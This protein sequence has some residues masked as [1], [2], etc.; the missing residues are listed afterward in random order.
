MAVPLSLNP[1][2]SVAQSLYSA[3]KPSVLPVEKAAPG[4]PL[5]KLSKAAQE[6]EG[7]L[8]SSWLDE[9]QKSSLDPSGEG[10]DAGAETFR[11]LGDHAV[12][13]ALAQRGG[14][15]IAQ[16]IVH[17]FRHVVGR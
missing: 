7:I 8:I 9:A 16:M 6:F 13:L 3:V 12:A 5:Q 10:Q 1:S 11:S 17:K 4:S 2:E 14:L 15:G